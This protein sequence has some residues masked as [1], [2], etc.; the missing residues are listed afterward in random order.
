M[1]NA[2]LGFPSPGDQGAIPTPPDV[3]PAKCGPPSA[4]LTAQDAGT[5]A[6]SSALRSH[7]LTVIVNHAVFKMES[8]NGFPDSPRWRVLDFCEPFCKG[9]L[10]R[11]P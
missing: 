1:D 10:D 5:T 7:G 4:P 11:T 2:S 9:K 8:A 6:A 3:A